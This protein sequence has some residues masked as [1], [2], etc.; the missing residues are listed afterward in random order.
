MRATALFLIICVIASAAPGC[1][2]EDGKHDVARSS[3]PRGGAHEGGGGEKKSPAFKSDGGEG[4]FEAHARDK[5]ADLGVGA[6]D[7]KPSIP[8]PA[9]AEAVVG[10]EKSRMPKL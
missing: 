5:A 7:A 6:A 4:N 8:P 1:G 10:V 9:V 3:A 2:K